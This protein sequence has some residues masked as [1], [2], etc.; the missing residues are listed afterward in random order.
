[1]TINKSVYVTY[2]L[3]SYPLILVEPVLGGEEEY[4]A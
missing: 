3:K 1:M 2:M 4:L